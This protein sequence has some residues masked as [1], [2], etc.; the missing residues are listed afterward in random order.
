[1]RDFIFFL[2]KIVVSV[3]FISLTI[4]FVSDRGLAN[5][6]N[7]VYN[8]WKNILEGN[9][10]SEVIIMGSSRGFVSYDSQIISKGLRLKTYNLSFNAAGFK[11]QQE[12][13]DIYL[14]KNKNPK[15]I[16]QN[17]DLAHFNDNNEIPD[18]NQFLPFI[19]NSDINR[20]ISK[21]DKKFKMIN[22]IPLIKYN[23]NFSLL[24]FGF[25]SNFYQQNIENQSTYNG[26]CPQNLPFKID[27]HNLKKLDYISKNKINL[28]L[29]KYKIQNIFKFYKERVNTKT[30]II[31]VWAPEHKLR[32]EDKYIKLISPIIEELNSIEKQN[33][34]IHFI[35]MSKFERLNDNEYFYDTFHLNKKGAKIFTTTLTDEITKIVNK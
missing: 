16:I 3:L 8:D 20:V 18:E 4:E 32:L 27:Y 10:N 9:I 14:K 26:F 7:S 12:K 21:Y 25:I 35:N 28:S 34:N 1:M 30:Q 17:I 13:L 6:K 19:F 5:L 2:L 11:L 22:Y 15:I 24:K 23:L 33:K 29:Y 31:F